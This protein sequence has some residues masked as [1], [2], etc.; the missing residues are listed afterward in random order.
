MRWLLFSVLTILAGCAE[1]PLDCALGITFYPGYCPT[2]GTAGYN[3]EHPKAQVV[4]WSKPGVT[5][6]EFNRD[7]YACALDARS[8]VSTASVRG[9][10]PIGNV[11]VPGSGT[12]QS[13]EGIN[14]TLFA[15]CME[16][17]GYTQSGND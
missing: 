4:N 13:G 16:A 2:P 15:Y 5:N 1:H 3:W 9:G 14:Q 8:N 10:M 6:E 12:A 17:K 11:W 7:R